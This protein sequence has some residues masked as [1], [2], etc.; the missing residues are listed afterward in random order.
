MPRGPLAQR[1]R[2]LSRL[3]DEGRRRC[4]VLHGPAGSGKTTALVFWRVELTAQ[5]IPVA[6]L[7][8]DAANSEFQPF[9]DALLDAVAEVDPAIV[10]EASS[11]AGRGQDADTVECLVIALIEGLGAYGREMVLVLEDL[12]HLRDD[13]VLQALQLLLDYM[14]PNLRCVLSSRSPLPVSVARLRAADQLMQIGFSDLRLDPA[15]SAEFLRLHLGPVPETEVRAL[16]D[17]TDGWVAGLRLLCMERRLSPVHGR[18]GGERVHTPEAFTRYFEGE[19]I[20]QLTPEFLRLLVCCA[21]PRR[22]NSALAAALLGTPQELTATAELLRQLENNVLFLAPVSETPG[23]WRVH[24]LLR[25]VLLQR[26]AQW[27]P[28]DQQRVQHAAW[29][30]F[31]GHGMNGEAVGHAVQAGEVEAAADLVERAAGVHFAHGELHRVIELVRA[32]PAA[33]VHRRPALRLWIAWIEMLEHRYDD[34]LRSVEQLRLDLVAA[35][36]PMRF[37]LNLMHGVLAMRMDDT[38]MIEEFLGE[39]QQPP[40]EIDSIV[41]SGARNL[42]SW[43]YL[44]RGEYERAREAQNAPAPLLD[45]RPLVSTAFGA[46]TGDCLVGLSHAVEGHVVVAERLYRNVLHEAA[47]RGIACNDSAYLAAGLLGEVL[48]EI[49]DVEGATRMLEPRLDVLEVVSIADSVLRAMVVMARASLLAR[50]PLDALGYLERLENYARRTRA[51][52]L[53]AHSLVEQLRVHLRRN[54]LDAALD[55]AQQLDQLQKLHANDR[56]P[57]VAISAGRAHIEV[58]TYRNDLRNAAARLEALTVY[59][60]RHGRFRRV[61]SLRM[62]A[63]A[64]AR[65]LDE[66][67]QAQSLLRESLRLGHRLGLVRSLVEAHEDSAAMI[68]ESLRRDALEPLLGFYAK[69]LLAAA[70]H[71]AAVTKPAVLSTACADSIEIEALLSEREMDIVRLLML[72][73]P[74]KKIARALGLSYQTVKWHLKNIFSKLAV[75]GRDEVVEAVR[76]GHRASTAKT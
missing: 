10:R 62:Q 39:L 54:N 8:F 25:E 23:W 60:E 14:P 12:H 63:A 69:R 37:R 24:P 13:R 53:L 74:N 15:E 32:L 41:K 34:C 35:D 33:L 40:A 71:S 52:R 16:H 47:Q 44:S 48:Y 5:G 29:H 2:L 42:L 17:L 72:A 59:C 68:D 4:I 49:D 19:V 55:C 50:R 36:A 58:C 45:G 21:V 6:W 7:S 70:S 56:L 20:S 75:N 64:V 28:G 30:W 43:Y 57:D 65:S 26:F 22:F 67:Q 51:V 66:P 46:L 11:L 76:G 3:R 38:R 18:P 27:P 1:P 61:A 31:A 9:I 73:M